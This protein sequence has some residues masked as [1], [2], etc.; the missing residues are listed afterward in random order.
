MRTLTLFFLATTLT[1]ASTFAAP[2]APQ[3]EQAMSEIQIT[4]VRPS[5]QL[6]PSQVDDIKGVYTLDN[7]VTFKVSNVHRTLVAQL[8]QRARTELVPLAANRFVAPGQRLT[9][10]WLPA[11]FGDAIVLTYPADPNVASSPMLTVRLAAH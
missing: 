6:Q 1:P 11:A 5:Y 2:Q 3:S 10:E 7:G 4:S 9:M 8:G